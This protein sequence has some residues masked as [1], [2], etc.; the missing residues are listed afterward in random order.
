MM[1]LK[2]TLL[3]SVATR[4]PVLVNTCTFTRSEAPAG[5]WTTKI[6]TVWFPPGTMRFLMITGS[7][8]NGGYRRIVVKVQT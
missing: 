6:S 2:G 4:L 7:R 8:V 5:G 1:L 3:T